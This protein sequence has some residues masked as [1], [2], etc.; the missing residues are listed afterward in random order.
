V[1][2][3][4]PTAILA[5]DGLVTLAYQIL[6]KT[7]HPKLISVTKLFTEGLLI[8]CE[9]QALDKIFENQKSVTMDEYMDMIH[10]KT[11]KLLEVTCVMGSILGNGNATEIESLKQFAQELGIAFQIQDDLLDLISEETVFGK[12]RGS[13]L[14]QK[15]QTY[16]T[17]HFNQN[18]TSAQK[19]SYHRLS[20]KKH[21]SE[22]DIQAV[23]L[24]F[25]ET[26]TLQNTQNVITQGVD[27]AIFNLSKLNTGEPRDILKSLA[28][29]IRD[30]VM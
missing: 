24:L 21:L 6:L 23:Q 10:K 1:Q 4:E 22:E 3:D 15:K 18:A 30:R 2:W 12:P 7:E 9:G 14:I 17:I 27:R 13:D 29:R 19:E 20:Q 26:G 8:L 28:M 25:K 11:A 5:G 16:L